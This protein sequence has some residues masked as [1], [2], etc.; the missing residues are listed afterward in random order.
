MGRVRA[1]LVCALAVVGSVAGARR[2][3]AQF[4]PPVI[5]PTAAA[6]ATPGVGAG[7]GAGA[8][9][10]TNPYMNPYL[11]PFLNPVMTQMPAPMGRSNTL[12]YFMAAQQANGML[13][14]GAAGGRAAASG[15]M[16]KPSQAAAT[17]P[18][19]PGPGGSR[20]YFNDNPTIND[21]G[22]RMAQRFPSTG[23]NRGGGAMA[24]D[25]GPATNA[26]TS[27]YFNRYGRRNA[28]GVH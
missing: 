18:P 23:P 24:P 22:G 12:L 4:A 11:N 8:N 26:S 25:R 21:R 14:P 15:G 27:R 16:A 7:L 9:P 19:A 10:Y 28:P 20:G 5:S 17:A 3:G 6:R 1:G 2:A 13:A